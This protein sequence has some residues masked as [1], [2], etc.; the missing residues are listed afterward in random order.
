MASFK[1]LFLLFIL[2]PIFAASTAP[3]HA[4]DL[5]TRDLPTGTCNANTPCVNGACCG[6]DNLCGYS[7]KSCATGCQ[8]NC[9]AKAECGPYAVAGSQGCPLNVCCSEFGFCGSTPEFCVWNNTA[10]PNYSECSTKYGGC[11]SVPRPSCGG[12]SGVSKRNV[13]YY[14]SWANTRSCQSVSPEDLNLDG[15]TSIN[16]AF[17]SF[18]ASSFSITPMDSNVGSLYSRFTA[19]KSKKPGLQAFISIG[20][21]SFT[22]PGPT[23][24]AYSNMVSGEGNRAMFIHNVINFMETYGFDGADLD[25]EYP[26]ADDRGGVPADTANYVALCKEMSAAFGTKFQLTVTIPTSYWYLQHFDLAKMQDSISWFNLMAYDLHGIWDAQSRYV[27]PYIAPHTNITEIDLALDLLWRTGVDSNK[28]VMG[29]G[30]YGR[31]FTLVDPSC[32]TPNS[33]CKFPST[34]GGGNPG[35]CS[36][37]SGILDYQEITDIIKKNSLTPV[38]DKTAGVKWITWDTNQWVSYDDADTFAQKRDFASSRC[39]GGMMVWGMDQ[40]EQTA[41]KGFG[42]ASGAA[43]I[44]VTPDQQANA[45][46]ATADQAATGSCYTEDCGVPCKAGTNEVAQYNGQPGQLSTNDRCQKKKYRSLCCDDKTQ[47]GTCTWRGYRGAGLSCTCG[48]ASGETEL[49]TNTNQ[50]TKKGDKNCHGGA[51]SFCCANFKPPTSSLKH[52]LEDAAKA[53]A[54]AAAQQA[55][56]DI[57]AK[58]F[59]SAA[60]LFLLFWRLWKLLR[61]LSQFLVRLLI[62]L[63][64]PQHQQSYKVASRVSRRRVLLSSKCLEKSTHCRDKSEPTCKPKAKRGSKIRAAPKPVPTKDIYEGDTTEF[65]IL[66]KASKISSKAWTVS[67]DG[68]G[69]AMQINVRPRFFSVPHAVYVAGYVAIKYHDDKVTNQCGEVVRVNRKWKREYNARE[70][71]L[72]FDDHPDRNPT[73]ACSLGGHAGEL[74]W[75]TSL[76]NAFPHYKYLGRIK[77][78][79]S[80][81]DI[82]AQSETV[83]ANM[84]K[85]SLVKNNC[86]T[87]VKKIYADEAA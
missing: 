22:D 80:N 5:Q 34:N 66:M 74:D 50:H 42:G 2:T 37:A 16:F 6:S 56:L 70:Y 28:V 78:G 48:C 82:I 25:W 1:S 65:K 54:E 7:A 17:A 40:V 81:S 39:L 10:D 26:G 23:Q 67:R 49:T 4:F 15:F 71:D 51:Q 11:G 46:Q 29:Q 57:A 41:S 60:L 45:N 85:Y 44:T 68:E 59:C 33:I 58:A 52:D 30:W 86:F 35:P 24:K 21:W 27:G 77:P 64:L 12:A 83:L 87:F 79:L 61:T 69:H 53:A 9:N 73:G 72:F 13:G 36:K 62:S 3:P 43:G 75:E 84:G 19:L 47:M 20:G 55:A 76:K 31:S 18:D 38:H 8:S 14:E 32:N 63:K